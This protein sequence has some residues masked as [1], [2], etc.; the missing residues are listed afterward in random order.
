LAF[1]KW[2]YNQWQW[3]P[4]AGALN[5]VEGKC[6]SKNNSDSAGAGWMSPLFVTLKETAAKKWDRPF[7]DQAYFW[8]AGANCVKENPWVMVESLR[9]INYLF[10]GNSTWPVAGSDIDFLYKI[11]APIFEWILLPLAL[12]GAWA[13]SR[14]Q[15][16]HSPK[17]DSKSFNE[18]CALL[19]LT[20]FFTVYIF[21]S[22]NRFRVP[23][24]GI[25]LMWSSLG[26]IYC[27]NLVRAALRFV[28]P[29]KKPLSETTTAG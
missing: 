7:T 29:N 5:F 20:I 11:W 16:S 12:I 26:V 1:T 15:N 21:K 10:Y 24:D 8:K 19:V 23:F 28:I 25:F 17:S 2:A 22:E 6:P 14:R 3:G 9:Y 27:G 13:F 4:T 18:V